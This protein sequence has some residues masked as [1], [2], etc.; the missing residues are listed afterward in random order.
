M[1]REGRN[2][3]PTTMRTMANGPGWWMMMIPV[4]KLASTLT[5]L[6]SIPSSAEKEAFINSILIT[7]HK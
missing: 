5:P 4:L 2:L 3:L 6:Q 1:D 7:Y